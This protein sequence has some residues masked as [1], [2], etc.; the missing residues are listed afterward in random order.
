M[1]LDKA[2]KYVF[3][4]RIFLE[5]LKKDSSNSFFPSISNV[6]NHG[7]KL[8]LGFAC[9]GLKLYKMTGKWFE[10]SDV[11]QK[12]YID[13][14]LTFQTINSEFPKNYFI[15]AALVESYNDIFTIEN[16]KFTLKKIIS[17]VSNKKYVGKDTVLLQSINAENKQAI[18]TLFELGYK[19]ELKLE[20]LHKETGSVTEYLQSLDWNKP[21]TSG[22]QFSSLCVY[23]KTQNFGYENELMDFINSIIDNET[24]S[25][26]TA[27][28]TNSREVIN[29]AM[30]V[31]TGL[32]WI[33]QQ[34]PFPKKLIDFCLNDIPIL[35][36][37]DV[38][39]FIY[40]LTKCSKQVDYRKEEIQG[41]LLELLDKIILLYHY[42]EKGFSY[43]QNKSQ[44]HYYG[45]RITKG[46]NV[47]DIHGTVLCVWAIN[48]ILDNFNMLD[49]G[50]HLIKP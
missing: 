1:E 3:D 31:I 49:D 44:T 26:H 33:D 23:S 27:G 10:L 45:T 48:L 17:S 25:F 42:E 5:N 40:V 47:A 28:V 9:Y 30:K 20:N 4:T 46:K 21:W 6:T 50:L 43:F 8:N 13:F 18:S 29:G 11:Q 39:D 38:V 32:D 12:E 14:L 37:C 34:I 19:K 2:K 41:V 7:S 15:D 24:G 35:E 22:A 16:F 36:G